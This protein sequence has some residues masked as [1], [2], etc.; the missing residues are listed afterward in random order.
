MKLTDISKISSSSRFLDIQFQISLKHTN[1]HTY[2][3]ISSAKAL[4]SCPTLCN[5]MDHSRSGF[6]VH[7]RL[8][9][10]VL[11]WVAISLSRVSSHL[12]IEPR[13]PALQVDSLPPELQRSLFISISICR[14]YD[15]IYTQH[16]WRYI[17][18]KKEIL[19]HKC[20]EPQETLLIFI[21]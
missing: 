4:H 2:I 13:S 5:P 3:Y 21:N 6:S 12:G 9:S 14:Q 18:I 20:S 15:S 7:E 8:Q 10:R 17:N 19:N 1:S 11:E 16:I